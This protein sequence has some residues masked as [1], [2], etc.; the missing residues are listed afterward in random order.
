MSLVDPAWL[1]EQ[2]TAL[3]ELGPA[4]VLAPVVFVALSLAF[5]P[6]VLLRVTTVV[7]FGPFLGP[8]YAVVG[9]A[10]CA[11]VGHALGAR[12]GGATLERNRIATRIR[13][14]V[15]RRGG[16]LGIAAMRFIPLGPFMV[17]NAA[18]GAARLRRS[19]F[20]AGTVLASLPGLAAILLFSAQAEALLR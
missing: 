11:W 4:S 2:A 7:V 3:R 10:L 8:I 19:H 9:V 17:V 16:I 20:V 6:L 18:A 1:L 13:E 5:V 12:V 15:D 14:L